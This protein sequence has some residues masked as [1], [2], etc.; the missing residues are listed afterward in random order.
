MTAAPPPLPSK[1]TTQGSLRSS[2]PFGSTLPGYMPKAGDV[3]AGKYQVDHKLGEGAM[4]VVF[5]V[6]HRVTQKRFALKWL[7]PHVCAR[8]ELAQRFLREAQVAGRVEHPHLVE[9]YDV[10]SLEGSFY[11]VLELLR[12]ES[13]EQRLTR[14]GRMSPA[15]SLRLLLPCLRGIAA[16]HEAGIVHRD[17]KP[18]NIFVCSAASTAAEHAKVLDFGISKL[19]NL[20]GDT[21]SALTR[22]G[23]VM[24][25]PRY[26][27]LEQMRGKPIDQRADI[28]ALGVVLYQ[29]LSGR[30]PYPQNNF[31]D[32]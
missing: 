25:T 7:L 24:G 20:P 12:G 28:Y 5:Q 16:A 22:T 27:P 23:L 11:M 31:G 4:S 10:G 2:D 8:P 9:V 30:L 18:A 19:P 3:I 21:R 13:L 14:V 17:L 29:M 26:M 32:L 6:T 15:D 1:S